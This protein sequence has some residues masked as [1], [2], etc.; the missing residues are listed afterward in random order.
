MDLL[1]YPH[2]LFSF[3]FMYFEALLFGSD[4]FM[5]V[6]S[7]WWIDHILSAKLRSSY[8]WRFSWLWSLLCLMLTWPFQLSFTWY[9]H[10]KSSSILL[11]LTYL[12][13]ELGFLYTAARLIFINHI[14]IFS[15]LFIMHVWSVLINLRP[16]LLTWLLIE[17]YLVLVWD[18]S[19]Q[20]VALSVGLFLTLRA[21]WTHLLEYS[22]VK[23]RGDFI[24]EIV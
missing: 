1:S 18:A 13:F 2:S 12:Y 10:G 17:F 11:L 22:S 14:F 19:G 24:F 9:F 21:F 7:F 5:I 20:C 3:C 15:P 16:V 4:T 8:P 6:M 23:T